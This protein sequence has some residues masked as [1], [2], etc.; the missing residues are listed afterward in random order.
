MGNKY[1]YSLYK[2]PCNIYLSVCLLYSLQ[3]TGF[4]ELGQISVLLHAVLVCMSVY[5]FIYTNIFYRL[6]PFLKALDAIIIIV[7]VYTIFRFAAGDRIV[8]DAGVVMEPTGTIRSLYPLLSIFSFYAFSQKGYL[9][10]GLL[11]RWVFVFIGCA[12]LSIYG[13]LGLYK[14]MLEVTGFGAFTN[15][16]GYAMLSIIPAVVFF[17]KK[18]IIQ[19]S[20]LMVI[21]FFVFSSM[22][23]GAMLIGLLC[24]IYF[25]YQSYKHNA[26]HRTAI[27]LVSVL[28][29]VAIS[30]Y[31]IREYST[32]EYFINRVEMTREGNSSN[33]DIIY[34]KLF[35]IYINQSSAFEQVFG[36]GLDGCAKNI[37]I[38]AHSDWIEFMFDM[39]V[40]GIGLLISFFVSLHSTANKIGKVNYDIF[41]VLG[42]AGLILLFQSV[43]STALSSVTYYSS[44]IIGFSLSHYKFSLHGKK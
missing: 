27:F 29:I 6:P 41:V 35:S 21:D 32:N 40:L 33:R 11:K 19:Y 5:Y 37:G 8:D 28:A 10:R 20:L 34:D 4:Y 36:H 43:F 38:I 23:R 42:M 44:C 7:S 22:K 2:N 30:Y 3:S 1:I 25:L 24:T 26:K 16:A 15:N 18:P 12:I 31:F 13:V 17:K 39:G 9:N 14:N